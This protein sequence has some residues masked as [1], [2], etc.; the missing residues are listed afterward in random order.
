MVEKV[1]LH[2]E[3]HWCKLKQ[4][5]GLKTDPYSTPYP[6]FCAVELKPFVE[7]NYY[8]GRTPIIGSIS[9]SI[10]LRFMKQYVMIYD[11][12]FFCRS[13]NIPQTNNFLSIAF[14]IFSVRLINAWAVEKVF[15]NPNCF[16]IEIAGRL[17]IS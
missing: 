15:W 3:A 16:C 17:R 13:K 12:K 6:R 11:I 10:M 1:L 5:R 4:R 7:T 8:W 2:Y 14:S 9:N